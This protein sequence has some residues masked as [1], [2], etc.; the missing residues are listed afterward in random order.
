MFPSVWDL[1]TP[2]LLSNC[3]FP[4]KTISAANPVNRR[5]A[6]ANEA[7]P[8]ERERDRRTGTETTD[9]PRGLSV[10]EPEK[11]IDIDISPLPYSP[12]L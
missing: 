5:L 8:S 1:T 9:Q 4:Q 6:G 7:E 11:E 10:N 2:L 12:D 3:Y